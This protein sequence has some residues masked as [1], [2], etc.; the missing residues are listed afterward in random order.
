MN[1]FD[2]LKTALWSLGSSKLRSSLTL[3]GIIIGIAAV[4]VLMTIGTSIQ[5]SITE[6]IQ[7]QGANLLFIQFQ[8]PRS[9]NTSDESSQ[10]STLTI[11]DASALVNSIFA[12]S[13]KSA[14]PEISIVRSAVYKGASLNA[15]IVGVTPEYESVRNAVVAHG[16]FFSLGHI[17]SNASVAIIS[18]SVS[19]SLFVAVR[20]SVFRPHFVP[21]Y[22]FYFETLLEYIS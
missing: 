18:A 3:L 13:I 17:E 22:L 1:P 10:S 8:A 4:M 15:R 6:R 9:L 5:K 14:A 7:S 12:P 16:D 21:N 20:L 2:T 11:S 19:E